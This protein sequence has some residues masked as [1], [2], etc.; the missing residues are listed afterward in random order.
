MED[1]Q[2]RLLPKRL[3]VTMDDAKN[4]ITISLAFRSFIA[5]QWFIPLLSLF[6]IFSPP[7][8]SLP[9]PPPSLTSACPMGAMAAAPPP[10]TPP[11]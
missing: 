9:H 6:P 7:T 4:T 11:A 2:R 10:P 8:L 1:E 5:K 3:N